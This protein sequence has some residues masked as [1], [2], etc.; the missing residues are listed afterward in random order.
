MLIAGKDKN[1]QTHHHYHHHNTH[2]NQQQPN[3]A[4]L[5]TPMYLYL[6]SFLF[7]LF[8]F[9]LFI[10]VSFLFILF[11]IYLT[12]NRYVRLDPPVGKP[13]RLN[14]SDLSAIRAFEERTSL[15]L[16][17]LSIFLFSHPFITI[18]YFIIPFVI[19]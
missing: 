11:I 13:L 18:I 10:C 14:E 7:G 12:V 9:F 8:L 2:N 5:P 6:F 19:I 15:Y 3:N 4:A 16:F 17:F 1:P